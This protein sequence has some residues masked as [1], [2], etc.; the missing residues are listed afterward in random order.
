MDEFAVELYELFKLISIYEKAIA[1]KKGEGVDSF[2]EKL[3]HY[4][5]IR[6]LI[7]PICHEMQLEE[8]ASH[9]PYTF[10]EIKEKIKELLS[11]IE[12]RAIRKEIKKKF[13]KLKKSIKSEQ[14]EWGTKASDEKIYEFFPQLKDKLSE[15][16]PLLPG[17]VKEIV[18]DYRKKWKKTY[19][20]SS[21]ASVVVRQL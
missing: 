3:N 18:V 16:A 9:K 14:L 11:R 8:I 19:K 15:I 20:V 1:D 21:V 7:E 13:K 5:K 10:E 17:K 6:N 4:K 12:D 2:T